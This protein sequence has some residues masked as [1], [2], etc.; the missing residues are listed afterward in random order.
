MAPKKN[1]ENMTNFAIPLVILTWH[2][3]IQ[4]YFWKNE[5][6]MFFQYGNYSPQKQ[7]FPKEA[8]D[9]YMIDISGNDT[10]IKSFDMIRPNADSE[11]SQHAC[12]SLFEWAHYILEPSENQKRPMRNKREKRIR[13]RHNSD[14]CNCISYR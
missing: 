9:L 12:L 5:D 7:R 3:M 13:H 2:Q 8:I 14:K 10:Q 11:V 1:F 6:K 4:E